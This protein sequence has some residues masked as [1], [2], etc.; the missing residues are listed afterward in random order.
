ML[1]KKMSAKTLIKDLAVMAAGCLI[2][3]A[4]LT[5]F[6]IPN[7]IAPGGTSGLATAIAVVVPLSVGLLTW[8]LNIPI[9]LASVRFL[10]PF[11]TVKTL[12]ASTLLS[13]FMELLPKVLPEFTGNKLMAAVLGGILI[14][15]GIGICFLR[16]ISMGG[17]DQASILLKKAF[18]NVSSGYLLIICD[19]IV[20]V[21]AGLVFRDLEVFL[22]SIITVA[23]ASKAIDVIMDGMNHARVFYIVTEKGQE[24]ADELNKCME[25]G[26]TL[27]PALGT[28]SGK[29][30]EVLMTV[31]HPNTTIQTL[32]IVKKLDEEAFTFMSAATEVHG[33]G[34][35]HYRADLSGKEE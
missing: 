10:G 14:G 13:L 7:H 16:G 34:F 22:Y 15:A 28:Y 1:R 24:I 9:L 21:I 20:V 8:L 26:V 5:M 33:K 2:T 11:V 27:I 31:V 12:I 4:G 6:T 3:A 32:E 30:K 19:G 18:P 35:I 29:K 17:T 23:V 25:N